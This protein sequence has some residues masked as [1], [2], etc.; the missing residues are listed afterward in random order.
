MLARI[1]RKR[2]IHKF[3]VGSQNVL[4]LPPKSMAVLLKRNITNFPYD[5]AIVLFL[6]VY[7]R[8]VKS[9]FTQK[10]ARECSQ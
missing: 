10:A 5:S 9:V 4:P 2:I 6:G 8:E 7:R 1:R 3:L